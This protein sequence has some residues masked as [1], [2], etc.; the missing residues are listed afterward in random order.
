M[1]RVVRGWLLPVLVL[2]CGTPPPVVPCEAPASAIANPYP[3][4]AQASMSFEIIL[5]TRS[6]AITSGPYSS[7]DEVN[8]RFYEQWDARLPGVGRL[9]PWEIA[10]APPRE[11]QF[12]VWKQDPDAHRR[13]RRVRSGRTHT[14]AM[15]L[16][17]DLQRASPRW[18]RSPERTL[19]LPDGAPPPPREPAFAVEIRAPAALGHDGWERVETGLSRLDADQARKQLTREP[20]VVDARVRALEPF[21]IID[22]QQYRI[23]RSDPSGRWKHG[24]IG[25]AVPN[26]SDKYD[27]KLVLDRP[28][29]P[30]QPEDASIVDVLRRAVAAGVFYFYAD[31]I[32]PVSAPPEAR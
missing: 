16:A 28:A 24:E 32:E 3:A 19:I 14:E 15:A 18:P 12:S 21:A 7:R 30:P 20:R 8:R 31:D 13:W 2:A 11:D 23:V 29:L 27:A 10:E 17:R 25:E 1:W 6:G 9:A 26:D 22:G 5:Y 4:P